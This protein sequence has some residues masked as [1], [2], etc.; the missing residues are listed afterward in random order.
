MYLLDPQTQ[1]EDAVCAVGLSVGAS[2]LL[3]EVG[4]S[5]AQLSRVA[6][7]DVFFDI[8]WMDGWEHNNALH[9]TYQFRGQRKALPSMQQEGRG[10]RTEGLTLCRA[11]VS[12]LDPA[13]PGLDPIQVV[14]FGGVGNR[15]G[16]TV[17][18]GYSPATL[19]RHE[20]NE[21]WEVSKNGKHT[22]EKQGRANRVVL[23][24][25]LGCHLGFTVSNCS[26]HQLEWRQ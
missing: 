10:S 24:Q 8:N 17:R 2:R 6:L 23:I 1:V 26:L 5:V 14:H 15:R 16:T 11:L 25:V 21:F 3:D 7:E 4:Q 9:W 20:C 22:T 18:C 19:D 13:L 12:S